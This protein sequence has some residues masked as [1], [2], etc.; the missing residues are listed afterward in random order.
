M[1]RSDSTTSSGIGL[2]DDSSD[3]LAANNEQVVIQTSRFEERCSAVFDCVKE[4]RYADD[5]ATNANSARTHITTSF[6]LLSAFSTDASVEPKQAKK[7][8]PVHRSRSFSGSGTKEDMPTKGVENRRNSKDDGFITGI[9]SLTKSRPATKVI[10][11]KSVF[12]KEGSQQ[13]Q[14]RDLTK[15]LDSSQD[16]M[17]YNPSQGSSM[18]LPAKYRAATPKKDRSGLPVKDYSPGNAGTLSNPSR[19]RILSRNSRPKSYKMAVSTGAQGSKRVD[20]VK[21][22]RTPETDL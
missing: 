12:A 15:R 11:N 9:A 14:Q 18:T 21:Q 16:K 13:Q 22:R 6:D 5:T 7:A 4:I 19:D 2:S 17:F 20:Q 10:S 1:K 8:N 3:N